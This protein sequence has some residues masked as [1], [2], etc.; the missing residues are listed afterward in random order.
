MGPFLLDTRQNVFT[1]TFR[2]SVFFWFQLARRCDVWKASVSFRY[3]FWRLCNT[4]IWSVLLRYH[5]VRHYEV[6]NLSVL[7][8]RFKDFSNRSVSLKYQLRHRDNVSNGL[9][10]P[11]LYEAK[12]RRRHDVQCR[13][14]HVQS[15]IISWQKTYLLLLLTVFWY[16]TNIGKKC[17][18]L[19]W[20]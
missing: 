8:R 4:L 1:F 9:W 18:W 16:C 10:Q 15:N 11:D 2:S 20:N 12:M 17:Y 7:L 3:Q 19:F 14:D 13:M 5:L 6:S